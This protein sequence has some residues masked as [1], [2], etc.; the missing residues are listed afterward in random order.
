MNKALPKI[1]RVKPFGRRPGIA[2]TDC[3]GALD[4]SRLSE[5]LLHGVAAA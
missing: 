2:F 4:S 3:K 1:I 5:S